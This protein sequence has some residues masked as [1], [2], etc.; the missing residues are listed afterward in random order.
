MTATQLVSD[1]DFH[2]DEPHVRR[3]Q[4]PRDDVL[5]L[6]AEA[7]VSEA[8]FDGVV[9]RHYAFRD[10]WFKV[11][12]TLDPA[13]VIVG[14]APGP[15]LPRFAFNC[16]I[17]T[18]M[19]TSGSAVY[20]VDLFADVL[21]KEDGVGRDVKDLAELDEALV[22]GLVSAYEAANARRGLDR[23][24]TLIDAG[25]LVAFLDDVC[26]FG[27]SR[28]APAVPVERVPLAAVPDLQPGRRPTWEAVP[29]PEVTP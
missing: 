29:P 22:D 19:A 24:L 2:P 18:P 20:A 7:Y 6:D 9:L 21:V 4:V 17:A 5:R 1:F 3:F 25:E 10:E 16:D 26:P 8:M 23:L 27:P 12:V 14:T 11:N 15:G 28:A 13:G